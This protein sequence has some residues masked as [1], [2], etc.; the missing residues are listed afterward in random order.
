[1]KINEGIVHD[2]QSLESAQIDDIFSIT[3]CN[4]KSCVTCTSR[5]CYDK[6]YTNYTTKTD[7]FISFNGSCQTKNCVYIIKCKREGCKYQYVGHT[8]NSI[9]SRISQHKS[10]IKRGGGCKILRDHFTKVHDISDMSIMPIKLLPENSTLGT[11]IGGLSPR[12]IRRGSDR[13][14]SD[15]IGSDRIRQPVRRGGLRRTQADPKKVRRVRLSPPRIRSDPIG[16]AINW[17]T[18]RQKKAAKVSAGKRLGLSPPIGGLSL[19]TGG[20]RPPREKSAKR[21]RRTLSAANKVRK[22]FSGGKSP[23]RTFSLTLT[24]TLTQG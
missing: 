20:L 7:Y 2:E 9:S 12:R 4:R 16:S 3:S 21:T 13:I 23:R 22:F 11:I 24:L 17:R 10:T 14:R 18:V 6:Y 1:M 5:L 8:I 15:P 19:P